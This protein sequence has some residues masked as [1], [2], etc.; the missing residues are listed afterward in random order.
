MEFGGYWGSG[1]RREGYGLR[2][3]AGC[4]L[5]GIVIFQRNI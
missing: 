5:D 4:K 2:A 3:K 1:H